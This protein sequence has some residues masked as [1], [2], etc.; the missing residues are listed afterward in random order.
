MLPGWE[1]DVCMHVRGVYERAGP[2]IPT[3]TKVI[4]SQWLCKAVSPLCVFPCLSQIIGQL[5]R[6]LNRQVIST[7]N[8]HETA[9]SYMQLSIHQCGLN[10][11]ECG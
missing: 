7:T 9:R 5:V 10:F 3:K 4:V 6:K 2:R 11:P 8:E 1:D